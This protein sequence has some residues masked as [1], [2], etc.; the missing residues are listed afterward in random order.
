MHR[1]HPQNDTL[2]VTVEVLGIERIDK[3]TLV[4]LAV[5][6]IAF[7]GVEI[8]VQGVQVRREPD[9]TLKVHS[10]CFRAGDGR[11]L[12]SVVFP[13]EIGKAV[14]DTVYPALEEMK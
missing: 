1:T 6:L 7:D 9:G 5:V 8:V 11:W 10:P 14:A 3:G 4:A 13:Q 2:P 12:P